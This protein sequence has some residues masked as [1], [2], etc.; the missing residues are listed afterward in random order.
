MTATCDEFPVGSTAIRFKGEAA[1]S[2]DG[3]TTVDPAPRPVL[4]AILDAAWMTAN[5]DAHSHAV[6]IR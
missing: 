2:F 4:P 5:A 1:K 6:C 3:E